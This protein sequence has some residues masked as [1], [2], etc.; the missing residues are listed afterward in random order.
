MQKLNKFNENKPKTEVFEQKK[1]VIVNYKDCDAQTEEE[2]IIEEKS[3]VAEYLKILNNVSNR[4]N[5]MN[6]TSI[7]EA[8]RTLLNSLKTIEIPSPTT[9]PELKIIDSPYKESETVVIETKNNLEHKY[10]NSKKTLTLKDSKET[11]TGL[12]SSDISS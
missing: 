7:V 6:H 10:L 9:T 2:A 11:Q 12:K 8:L 1:N 5:A 4:I 3:K